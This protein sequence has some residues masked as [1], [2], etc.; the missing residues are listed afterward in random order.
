MSIDAFDGI[1]SS[2]NSSIYNFVFNF[3]FCKPEMVMMGN[4][5][6]EIS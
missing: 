3:I 5:L 4:H 6:M 1:D 2:S